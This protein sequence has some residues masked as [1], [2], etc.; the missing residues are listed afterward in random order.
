[1]CLRGYFSDW[2]DISS[3]VLQGSVLGPTLFLVY[4]NNLPDS[5]LSSLYMFADDT[6]IYHAIN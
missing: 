2:V 4:V 5:V 6:K 3:G 1:M